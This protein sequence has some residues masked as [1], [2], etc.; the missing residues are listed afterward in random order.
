MKEVFENLKKAYDIFNMLI[1]KKGEK[2]NILVLYF[3]Y[4]PQKKEIVE[5]G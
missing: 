5:K 1:L 4:T 3:F 2:H